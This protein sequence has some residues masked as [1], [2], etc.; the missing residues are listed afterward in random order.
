MADDLLRKDLIAHK[1]YSAWQFIEYTEK[2]ISTVQYCADTLN[3]IIGKMT[4]KTIRWQQDIAADFVDCVTE[5]GKKV[6]KLAIT[7]ENSP[8]YELRVA[9]E[10]VDPWFLFDKLLRDFFQYTMNALDSMSQIINAGLLANK[11]K[12]VDSVDIQIMTRTFNQQTYSAA[13]PKMQTWLNNISQSDEFK[14]IEA[15]NNRTKHTAD[16]ANKLSMGILGSSNKTEIGPFFRKDVQHEK[17]EL[18]DQLQAT[19]DF[20]N[21]TWS[22]FLVLFKEEYVRDVYTENRRHSISG[23]RQ[24]K[25]KEEPDQD[26][27][28]A[29]IS[30]EKDFDSMPDEIYIL[31]VSDREESVYVHECPFDTIL[32]AGED[33]INVLGRY[34]ADQIIGDE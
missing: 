32:V 7:T 15:I 2:N 26:L 24:Q 28:Y 4:M 17:M 9:G 20:L 33:N 6:K 19:L 11:G 31:L 23:V 8:A 16:I 27:S 1:I 18:S 3:N 13:F 30:T 21:K 12:A 14:Y 25:L 34:C 22:D 5:D 10:K 29:Y